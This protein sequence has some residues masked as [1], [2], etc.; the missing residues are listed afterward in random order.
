MQPAVGPRKSAISFDYCTTKP[1]V[2][3]YHT[4]SLYEVYYFHA[5]KCSYLIGDKIYILA[6]GDLI[7]MYGMTLHG[8]NADP[9]VPYARSII[10]FEPAL[11]S[12]F[13]S[14][15]NAVDLL[16]PFRELRN[17]RISLSG[18][19]KDEVERLLAGM[20]E[21]RAKQSSAGVFRM[22]LAFID[23]LAILFEK[24]SR[25][26][27]GGG[28]PEG[29]P[30]KEQIVQR[31]LDFIEAHYSRDIHLGELEAE[32]HFSKSYLAKLFKDVTGMTIFDYL[33]RRRINQARTLFQRDPRRS[34][35]DVSLETGFK[36]LAHFCRMFKSHT[37]ETPQSYR[38]AIRGR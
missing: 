22:Q 33:Y 10:H 11:L 7:L 14:V 3:F 17:Y 2:P 31:V 19:D 23:L 13:L 25:I 8:A 37:G 27:V 15:P 6:P 29:S 21:H 24:C 32:L 28:H 9:S 16:Q 30:D 20:N 18:A 4:H 26:P 35:T 1:N 34:V 38:R 5:G 12:P 36:H